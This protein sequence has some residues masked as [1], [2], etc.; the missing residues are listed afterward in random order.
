MELREIKERM[1]TQ[2]MWQI[3]RDPVQFSHPVSELAPY[4][5]Y[6]CHWNYTTFSF[7]NNNHYNKYTGKTYFQLFDIHNH[8]TILYTVPIIFHS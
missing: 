2:V 6:R 7:Q 4:T 3:P 1:D 8:S 5:E